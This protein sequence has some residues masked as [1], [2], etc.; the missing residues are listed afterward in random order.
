MCFQ[1]LDNFGML[2]NSIWVLI[3]RG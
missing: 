3:W 2:R 1:K